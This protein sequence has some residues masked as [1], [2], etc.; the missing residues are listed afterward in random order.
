MINELAVPVPHRVG[1][2]EVLGE[3]NLPA[4]PV[5]IG[6][7]STYDRFAEF[8]SLNASLAIMEWGLGNTLP[9]PHL[10]A[11]HH[12]DW[13]QPCWIIQLGDGPVG[14]GKKGN[15]RRPT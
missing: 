8:G 5:R 2:L 7:A 1:G 4:I 9:G 6:R 10:K 12:G 13:C 3:K 15:K 14:V 11:L